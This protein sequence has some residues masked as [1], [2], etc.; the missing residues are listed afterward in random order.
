MKPRYPLGVNYQLS[1][2]LTFDVGYAHLFV[3][4]PKIKNTP[5]AHDPKLPFP[6]GLTG[7]H[8]LNADY[9]AQVDIISAQVNWKFL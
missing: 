6:A 9:D 5:D 1:K 4:D 8:S 2:A 3:E 7:F